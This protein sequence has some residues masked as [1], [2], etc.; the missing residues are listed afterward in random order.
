MWPFCFTSTEA[1]WFIRDRGGGG[2]KRMK[3]WGLN[4]RYCLKK[5]RETMDRRQNNV[6]VKA[7]SPRHCTATSALRNCCLNCC[8]GQNPKDNVC[9]TGVEEQ[10]EAKEVQLSQPSST[11]S[12][13]VGWLEDPAPLD[14]TW[15]PQNLPRWSLCTLY[16]LAC[17][18]RV[19]AGHSGLVY[20]CVCVTALIPLC[21]DSS[22]KADFRTRSANSDPCTTQNSP[23]QSEALWTAAKKKNF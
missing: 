6:S 16:L 2:E 15:N 7:V 17:Q 14:L 3:E 13:F 1:R 10:L 12:W 9:C 23:G 22:P 18:M 20:C 21:V 11:C 5:T 19:T 4:C 8:A